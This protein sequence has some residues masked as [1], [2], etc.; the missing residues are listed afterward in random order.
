M[1]LSGTSSSLDQ[2]PC[3]TQDSSP[4]LSHKFV[5]NDNH[6]TSERASGPI[7]DGGSSQQTAI[8]LS[9]SLTIIFSTVCL[10][11]ASRSSSLLFSGSTFCVSISGSPFTTAAHHSMRFTLV[12]CTLTVRPPG[13]SSG[14]MCRQASV[15]MWRETSGDMCR[16]ARREVGGGG[17]NEEGQ[18]GNEGG[19]KDSPG[20]GSKGERE[21]GKEGNEGTKRCSRNNHTAPWQPTT[22]AGHSDASWHKQRVINAMQRAAA[23][24]RQSSGSSMSVP[25]L[26][27]QSSAFTGCHNSPCSDQTHRHST[28][29]AC[30]RMSIP[31]TKL[32]NWCKS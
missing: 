5:M 3:L 29:Q 12:R 16:Q 8:H 28:R 2:R 9:P 10:V 21:K 7:I 20:G 4:L 23:I 1:P 25:M 11:S 26:H 13:L 14:D 22:D 6:R 15:E 24:N 19:G 17:G 27:R 30:R 32:S 31:V 18:I